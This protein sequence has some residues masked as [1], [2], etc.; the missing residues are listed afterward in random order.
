MGQHPHAWRQ[1]RPHHGSKEGCSGARSPLVY[2][3]ITSYPFYLMFDCTYVHVC[4][5]P[6]VVCMHIHTHMTI[7]ILVYTHTHTYTNTLY[8]LCFF[9][10]IG[11]RPEL[12]APCHPG[13]SSLQST[14][15]FYQDVWM[16][17]FLLYICIIECTA[18]TV[19]AELQPYNSV[20]RAAFL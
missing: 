13:N 19:P 15:F 14:T 2:P 6:G 20:V 3:C 17:W 5:P 9:Q 7:Y 10:S 8:M 12:D 11:K 1:E 4:T 16:V 18:R